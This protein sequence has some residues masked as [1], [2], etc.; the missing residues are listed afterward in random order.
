MAD[1]PHETA[2]I[3]AEGGWLA[4]VLV[5]LWVAG[6][7]VRIAVG[8]DLKQVAHVREGLASVA[9]GEK[10]L[11]RISHAGRQLDVGFGRFEGWVYVGVI[12]G[13]AG[14]L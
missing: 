11:A 2:A 5:C 7:S 3:R 8:L 14:A 10:A 4:V 1:T 9:L 12:V 13:G 6:G